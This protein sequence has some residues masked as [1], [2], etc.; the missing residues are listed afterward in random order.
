[1][2]RRIDPSWG[3]PIELFLVQPVLH[4]WCNKGRGMCYPVCGMVHIKEPLLLI[5]KSSLC[6]GSGFPF[7]LSEWSLTICLTPVC[8]YLL[9]THTH[10]HTHTQHACTHTHTTH[11]HTHTHE[12]KNSSVNV[13]SQSTWTR[14][15]ISYA[16]ALCG[17]VI[18][19]FSPFV[20]LN[21]PDLSLCCFEPLSHN[22]TQQN[23]LFKW[24]NL[25]PTHMA[26]EALSNLHPTLTTP[27][28]ICTRPLQ[29]LRDLYGF[30]GSHIIGSMEDTTLAR[31]GCTVFY[32]G[33]LCDVGLKF[34]WLETKIKKKKFSVHNMV[35]GTQE[36]RYFF[37]FIKY[38]KGILSQID[39]TLIL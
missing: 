35:V 37:G 6:G 21:F 11:T 32:L 33:T 34:L 30:S 39:R 15:A 5:D 38:L 28:S 26:L 12:V 1:M 9:H 13:R 20:F 31:C 8:V 36:V 10:T 19:L 17:D 24:A 27:I 14:W 25:K 2:G 22:D 29:N 23:W 7:S 18:T 4:D 3:G 16:L